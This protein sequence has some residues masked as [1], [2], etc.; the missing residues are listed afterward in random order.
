MSSTITPSIRVAI[1]LSA[2]VLFAAGCSSSSSSPDANLDDSQTPVESVPANP[3]TENDP[4]DASIDDQAQVDLPVIPPADLPIDTP[5]GLPTDLPIDLP[6]DSPDLPADPALP[7]PPSDIPAFPG[8][9]L[10]TTTVVDFEI[11]VPAFSSDALQLRVEWGD[12]DITAQWV[13]D[14]L[15]SVEA[16]F[17][18]DTQ[19]LLTITFFDRN[20]EITLASF[21]QSFRTG[22]N[23]LE[24]FTVSAN[25]FDSER[26]DSDGDGISNLQESIAGTDPFGSPRVLLFSETRGFRHPSIAS[27]LVAMEELATIAGIETTRAN[28]SSNLF[29]DDNLASYDA[30][31]WVLTSGDV[32]NDDEQAAFELYIQSGG[33][34]AGIHAASD[35]EYQWPWYGRLVGAYFE[36]H[37]EI[38]SATIDVENGSHQSTDHLGTTWTRT[39]EWYDFDVNPRSQVN[40]LLT[41]DEDSYTGGGMGDDHP[42]AWFHEFDGG[43]SWYTGG[44]HTDESYSEPDFREHLLGGLRYVVGIDG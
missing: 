32:L 35:T 26:W 12:S 24:V 11:T 4:N 41:L 7:T 30:V 5:T 1:A 9:E 6:T 29:T 15:W 16:D 33:G 28:D 19:N 10:P 3:D 36:R 25:Q 34:Y 31:I 40:V 2:S 17:P 44:G 27:A 22:N 13:G 43:R 37:P 8:A 20:G 14:E 18:T 38:Q 21:E 23:D 39:D 42:I